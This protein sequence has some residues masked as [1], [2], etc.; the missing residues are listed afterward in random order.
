V[1][2]GLHKGKVIGAIIL[3]IAWICCFLFISPTLIIDFG[4]GI[5]LPFKSTL[6]FLGLLIL[7]IYHFAYRSN[8]ETTKLSWTVVFSIAWLSL[9]L[10]YPFKDPHVDEGTRGAVAFFTLVGGLAFCLFWIRFFSDEITA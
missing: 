10:F 4:A 6:I 2:P 8:P 7:F 5:T 1:T 9:I 3:S